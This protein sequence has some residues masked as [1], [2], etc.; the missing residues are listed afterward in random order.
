[1]KVIKKGIPKQDRVAEYE[2]RN[3]NSIIEVK[4]SELKLESG[5]RND[6]YKSF[7]CPVCKLIQ[8]VS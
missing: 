7:I 2:C 8:Y 4:N 3:C 6:N 1:M 5:Y